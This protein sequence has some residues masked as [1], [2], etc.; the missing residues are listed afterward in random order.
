[1]D[2]MATK[3]LNLRFKFGGILM[4]EVGPIYVGG[5]TEYVENVDKDHLSILELVDYAKSF[6]I[7]IYVCHD[8]ILEDVGST[9][10]QI[11]QSL[12]QVVK[13]LRMM[14]CRC[15]QETD[16]GYSLI[17]WTDT[18]EE[19][20]AEPSAQENVEKDID[21][22]SICSNQS[23]DY[24]SDVHEELRIVKEDVRKV[25][26][27]LKKA[28]KKFKDKLIEDEPYYD[29][30]DCDSFQSDEEE[31]V[32]DDE[33]EG[34][35]LRGRKKSNRVIYDSTCDVVIWQ[36]GLVFESVKKFREV[37]TKYAIKKELS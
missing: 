6:G 15:Q 31:P 37:V 7:N 14:G 5:R 20:K 3:Y 11:S 21:N 26:K 1:I 35:S 9:E 17:D 4:S 2:T 16:D 27:I 23:I 36:C 22:D 30:F 8:T 18:E 25:W 13:E 34:G 33:L 28:K 24:G 32:S 10:G 12:S 29:N 19:E